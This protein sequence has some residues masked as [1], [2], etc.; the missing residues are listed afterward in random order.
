MSIDEM[1]PLASSTP[2]NTTST[3]IEFPLNAEETHQTEGEAPK[4]EEEQTTVE[5]PAGADVGGSF[6]QTPLCRANDQVGCVIAY[7]SYRASDPPTSRPRRTRPTRAFATS[8]PTLW[9]G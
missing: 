2:G 8:A 7:A 5:V 1:L 6:E 4:V 3:M 9:P